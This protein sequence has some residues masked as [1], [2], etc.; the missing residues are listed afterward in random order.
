[1]K[2]RYFTLE[3]DDRH[4]SEVDLF[5]LIPD[6]AVEEANAWL[7]IHEPN[8]KKR[9]IKD[10]EL[11]VRAH[12]RFEICCETNID[13]RN[14]EFVYNPLSGEVRHTGHMEGDFKS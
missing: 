12:D 9:E 10:R 8:L 3:G 5:D 7:D 11:I 6:S 2:R 13:Y 14:Y 1:M 4:S